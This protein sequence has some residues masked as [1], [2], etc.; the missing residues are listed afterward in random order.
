MLNKE[1]T[2]SLF[3]AVPIGGFLLW[4]AHAEICRWMNPRWRTYVS[5]DRAK[6][7]KD[8]ALWKR[9]A[10][11]NLTAFNESQRQVKHWKN[12]SVDQEAAI[13][14]MRDARA[15]ELRL[16]REVAAQEQ[17]AVVRGLT[18]DLKRAQ[19]RVDLLEREVRASKT[20]SDPEPISEQEASEDVTPLTASEIMTAQQ[21]PKRFLLSPWMEPGFLCM[22]HAPRGVGKTH[23][24]IGVANAVASGGRFLR[25]QATKQ[26]KVVFFDSEMGT[27]AVR[28]RIKP[29]P[30]TDNI[31]FITTDIYEV[32]PKQGDPKCPAQIER[33]L[34]GCELLVLDNLATS[35]KE[36]DYPRYWGPFEQWIRYLRKRGIAVL[37]VHHSGKNGAQ[38]GRSDKED[39]LNVVIG[40]RR[41]EG[42]DQSQGARFEVH[43]EKGRNLFGLDAEPFEARLQDGQWLTYA[44]GV[45]VD[46]APVN[47]FGAEDL[48]Q[49]RLQF[50]A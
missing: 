25:W 14:A 34:Q 18:A 23:V 11:E 44:I 48:G 15:S 37:I 2:F 38:R 27:E 33:H 21:K 8:I 39:A 26:R 29:L 41:P 16:A 40:L 10:R 24:S 49:P 7:K 47:S 43:F 28:E 6:L 19:A 36:I 35:N 13:R 22:V 50:A 45:G 5:G 12:K 46:D 31:A 3:F 1:V 30:A 17:A 20:K 4:W 32:M 42:Y 9:K